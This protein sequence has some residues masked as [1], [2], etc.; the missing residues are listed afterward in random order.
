MLVSAW[1]SSEEIEHALEG[2]QSIAVFSCNVCANLNGTGGARGLRKMTALLRQ[3]NKRVVV[4]KTVNVCCSE[5]IL[6]Q[7]INIH[8]RPWREV[9]DALVMLSC[10]GGVKCAFLCD[11][12]VPVIAVTDSL[13]SGVISTSRPFYDVGICSSCDHC[14]LTWT[15]GI[16]P[17]SGCPAKKKYG[18]CKKAPDQAGPC[19]VDPSRMCVWREIEKVADMAALARLAEIHGQKDYTRLPSAT[20]QSTPPWLRRVSGR[21]MARI[22]GLSRLVD[23][24]R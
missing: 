6:Q 8:I 22:P 11:P 13:G 23:M 1:K 7:Y 18:P 24:V 19:T 4:A 12:G 5:E 20:A 21:F 15:A 14:V 17:V 10:A 16:C 2:K 9:C 3:W